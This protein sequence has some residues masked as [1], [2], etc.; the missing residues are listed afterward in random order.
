MKA[1]TLRKLPPEVERRLAL[2]VQR[3]GL[4]LNR[5]VIAA[6]EEAFGVG[7]RKRRPAYDDLDFL[8]GAWSAEEAE[9]FDRALRSR[10]RVDPELWK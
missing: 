6:L 5:A 9:A 8:I 1:I 10:R 3:E 4:S 2:K 7:T